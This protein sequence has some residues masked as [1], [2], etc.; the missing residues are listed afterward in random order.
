LAGDTLNV[1]GR[2]RPNPLDKLIDFPP[3]SPD[4]FGLPE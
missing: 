4:R 1:F 2:Y 3:P